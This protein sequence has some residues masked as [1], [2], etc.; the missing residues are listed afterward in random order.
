MPPHRR[1]DNPTVKISNLPKTNEVEPLQAV[2][3]IKLGDFGQ[4][5]NLTKMN[6]NAK[7]DKFTEDTVVFTRFPTP[8]PRKGKPMNFLATHTLAE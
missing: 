7:E 8:P 4:K 2:E 6:G 3:A 5:E 1:G